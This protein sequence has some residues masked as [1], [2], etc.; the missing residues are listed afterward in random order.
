MVGIFDFR[1]STLGNFDAVIIGQAGSRACIAGNQLLSRAALV[2]GRA[3]LWDTDQTPLRRSLP[4][5]PA[6][7]LR[8]ASQV[9][10]RFPSLGQLAHLHE[11]KVS[12]SCDVSVT[13]S[14]K[15][16][17]SCATLNHA[18]ACSGVSLDED[19]LRR[20]GGERRHSQSKQEDGR[21]I[22]AHNPIALAHVEID[23]RVI[24]GRR[25]TDACEL[26]RTDLYLT[27][28]QVVF[29]LRVAGSL[30]GVLSGRRDAT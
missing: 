6:G 1:N 30:H 22:R 8:E 14:K 5:A 7:E 12:S 18:V 17:P 26:S 19:T 10:G 24:V 13:T 16:D 27:D 25:R 29:E 11:P 9:L 20:I 15:P 21:A 4:E 23:M 28:A 3:P 2:G